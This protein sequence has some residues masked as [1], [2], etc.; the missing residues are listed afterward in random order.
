MPRINA[1]HSRCSR[2]LLSPSASL[3]VMVC[4]S[5]QGAV[6][7]LRLVTSTARLR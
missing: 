3:L 5:V 2:A 1:A 6:V 7:K 4:I